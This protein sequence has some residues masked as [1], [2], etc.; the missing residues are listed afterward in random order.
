MGSVKRDVQGAPP[1]PPGDGKLGVAPPFA[2]PLVGL[3][4]AW[5]SGRASERTS[6][7]AKSVAHG[8]LKPGDPVSSTGGT[9]SRTCSITR[10]SACC[11]HAD[12]PGIVRRYSDRRRGTKASRHNSVAALMPSNSPKASREDARREPATSLKAGSSRLRISE[13]GP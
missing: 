11:S 5:G 12:P 7:V 9:N 10:P 6:G 1:S 8:V 4:F 3:V 2:L 13:G